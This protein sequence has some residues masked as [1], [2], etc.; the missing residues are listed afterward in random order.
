MRT[1]AI[2][3][4]LPPTSAF[5][6]VTAALIH[7]WPFIGP[8]PESVHVVD[9]AASAVTHRAGLV[10]HA[11]PP[12]E[13]DVAPLRF[14][15]VAVRTPLSTAVDIART[16]TPAAA[17]VAIDHEVRSGGITAEQFV[18]RLPSEPGRG[19]RRAR[20]VAAALDS[21]HES[22]GESYAAIRLVEAGVEGIVPQHEFRTGG[23][24]DRVDFWLPEL[25]VVVEFDGRQKYVDPAMLQGRDAGE[26]LWAEKVREDRIRSRP[27]VRSVIR[28][29]WWHLESLDRFRALFRSHGVFI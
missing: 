13:F 27:E 16:S 8:V 7:G 17:C 10:R 24:T 22:P 28:V 19:T 21:R 25:G 18:Q 29:T 14:D 5:S 3:P 23:Q 15:G 11:V 2:A 20:T 1:W 12:G 4:V 9:H 26:V 6:H